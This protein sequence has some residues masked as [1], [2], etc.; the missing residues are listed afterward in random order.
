M[1]AK[2]RRINDECII[3]YIFIVTNSQE[4]I[5]NTVNSG[6]AA[7]A[8]NPQN[9]QKRTQINTRMLLKDVCLFTVEAGLKVF[10]FTN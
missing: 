7:T 2:P 10:Y 8:D 4:P 6:G 3:K 9:S 1:E 5:T